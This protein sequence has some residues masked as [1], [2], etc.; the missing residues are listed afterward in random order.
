MQLCLPP[1][2]L[3]CQR[4]NSCMMF[5]SPPTSPI[6]RYTSMPINWS[7]PSAQPSTPKKEHQK[8]S[9]NNFHIAT[10]HGSLHGFKRRQEVTRVVSLVRHAQS[11]FNWFDLWFP[12]QQGTIGEQRTRQAYEHGCETLEDLDTLDKGEHFFK[13]MI[14]AQL[15]LTG[16]QQV[17]DNYIKYQKALAWIRSNI[18]VPNGKVQVW[19]SVLRRA[20]LTMSLMGLDTELDV[21]GPV[22][23]L[24]S[25]AETGGADTIQLRPVSR[26]R[27]QSY[28][29]LPQFERMRS[30][31]PTGKKT[32]NGH[33]TEW[34]EH[35]LQH[36]WKE[37]ESLQ[38]GWNLIKDI[39]LDSCVKEGTT[40]TYALGTEDK[41]QA[42]AEEKIRHTVN[43]L[44]G[45]CE[46]TQEEYESKEKKTFAAERKLLDQQFRNDAKICKSRNSSHTPVILVGHSMNWLNWFQLLLE[47]TRTNTNGEGRYADICRRMEF[48]AERKMPNADIMSFEI[49]GSNFDDVRVEQFTTHEENEEVAYGIFDCAA[50]A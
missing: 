21:D 49:R 17:K 27:D 39:N 3:E 46:E 12:E 31:S 33:P 11:N 47:R 45:Y 19:V 23:G 1:L 7:L 15:T 32:G 35:S 4:M 38:K 8:K 9:N 50:A 2:S 10:P 41:F 18:G 42:T 34:K 26:I 44:L 43:M 16:I 5:E 30:D 28:H 48:F 13:Y 29:S 22:I 14:D 20:V 24:A 36:L 25:L 6:R 40:G 37:D